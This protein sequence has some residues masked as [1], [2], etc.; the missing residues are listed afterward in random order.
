MGLRGLAGCA[1]RAQGSNAEPDPDEPP[2]WTLWAGGGDS[3][4][5]TDR[6]ANNVP[7]SSSTGV[8][9]TGPNWAAKPAA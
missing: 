1:G 9:E 2:Y 6:F 5:P 8:D 3:E 4:S 7:W